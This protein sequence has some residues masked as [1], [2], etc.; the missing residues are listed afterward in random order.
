MQEE[1]EMLTTQNKR[2]HSDGNRYLPKLSLC[3]KSTYINIDCDSTFL[4][5]F[6]ENYK[7]QIEV[8]RAQLEKAKAENMLLK[9]DRGWFDGKLS[10]TNKS[11][12]IHQGLKSP[13]KFQTKVLAPGSSP[14][15]KN[16]SNFDSTIDMPLVT[17][18]AAKIAVIKPTDGDGDGDN[19]TAI[20]V[21]RAISDESAADLAVA[22][23]P[24]NS[25][26]GSTP[27]SHGSLADD[28]DSNTVIIKDDRIEEEED[29]DEVG[30]DL[31]LNE[32]GHDRSRTMSGEL[33]AEFIRMTSTRSGTSDKDSPNSDAT[34]ELSLKSAR[35]NT[36]T[37]SNA[38]LKNNTGNIN[39]S[40]IGKV[41]TGS[42]TCS[43]TDLN[44]TPR[45]LESLH[46]PNKF[47]HDGL[48]ENSENVDKT[49][50]IIFQ[51]YKNND[52]NPSAKNENHS[53]AAAPV[54]NVSNGKRNTLSKRR[55]SVNLDNGQK[56]GLLQIIDE[57][58]IT[59]INDLDHKDGADEDAKQDLPKTPRKRLFQE[60]LN[61]SIDKLRVDTKQGN[62]LNISKERRLTVSPSFRRDIDSQ[63]HNS[64][65]KLGKKR[66][67]RS[68]TP[69][70]H[71]T[72]R[73]PSVSSGIRSFSFG[74][75]GGGHE[76][77]SQI[78]HF[79]PNNTGGLHEIPTIVDMDG[80]DGDDEFEDD[81][82]QTGI[83]SPP[84]DDEN[85]NINPNV[86]VSLNNENRNNN[87][88][89]SNCHNNNNNTN[90]NKNNDNWNKNLHHRLNNG[91]FLFSD[92]NDSDTYS[93]HDS[94]KSLNSISSCSPANDQIKKHQRGH[95]GDHNN[96]NDNN[97]DHGRE[98][99]NMD[100]HDVGYDDIEDG[101]D[102]DDGLRKLKAQNWD[103]KSD[104]DGSCVSTT[105]TDAVLH[106]SDD[107]D[108]DDDN[109]GDGDVPD[110]F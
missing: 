1:H 108:D 88:G 47:Q 97:S 44:G 29:E 74:H 35:S 8:L 30:L 105:S 60:P 16:F 58:E 32:N 69:R 98:S 62:Y 59:S 99:V 6:K 37:A 53:P 41:G 91:S 84:L 28:D 38:S 36:S 83:F 103:V 11:L 54:V 89:S 45:N 95:N 27:Q 76:N 86:S 20:G 15:P 77:L 34:D 109:D 26:R 33:T 78:K 25:E 63:C 48:E 14:Y 65:I 49:N 61:I 106:N 50:K 70:S 81:K 51:N 12:N 18:N 64:N 72:G 110:E 56:D 13:I 100:D 73:R 4:N 90:N 31:E 96:N 92:G 40:N 67:K 39:A 79:N 93:S 19:I 22:L 3:E 46:I 24:D 57:C 42:N 71:G 55:K 107:D 101:D 80:D 52:D 102:S 87:S 75:G 5:S 68:T 66:Q 43:S 82:V 2:C 94:Q 85:E 23:T 7:S 10:D 21:H 104:S 9:R 17:A